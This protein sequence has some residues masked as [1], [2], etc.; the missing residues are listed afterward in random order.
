VNF[1]PRSGFALSLCALVAAS[2]S[3]PDL[4]QQHKFA[5]LESVEHREQI[6]KLLRGK[7]QHDLA[8]LPS[9]YSPSLN[10]DDNVPERNSRKKGPTA[11]ARQLTQTF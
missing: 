9:R 2:A 11:N 5:V 10:M 6:A 4:S 1:G 3:G 7:T 8:L